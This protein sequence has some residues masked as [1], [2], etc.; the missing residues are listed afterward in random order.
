MNVLQ[1]LRLS[2]TMLFAVIVLPGTANAQSHLVDSLRAAANAVAPTGTLADTMLL[3]RLTRV[4]AQALNEGHL[5][6]SLAYNDRVLSFLDGMQERWGSNTFLKKLSL[7]TYRLRAMA[8]ED[9]GDLAASLKAAL[10]YE[11]LA[12]EMDNN[13]AIGGSL[14]QQAFCYHALSDDPNAQRC[15]HAA[16]TLLEQEPPG[17]D[18]EDVLNVLGGNFSG[19]GHSD[20]VFYYFRRLAAV[21]EGLGDANMYG[22]ACLNLTE[23]FVGQG[24]VDSAVKYMEKAKEVESVWSSSS[25]LAGLHGIQ[26]KVELMQGHY[27]RALVLADSALSETQ[28]KLD[29][30]AQIRNVRALA[31]AALGRPVEGYVEQ[32]R[33]RDAFLEDQGQERVRALAMV[34]SDHEREKEQINAKQL[35]MAEQQRKR[36]ITWGAIGLG[37][38]AVSLLFLFYTSRKGARKLA[39]KNAEILKAQEQLVQSEKQREAEQ[40]RTRIARDIHDEIGSELTKITLLGSEVKRLAKD[41]PARVDEA[42]ERMRGS[43]RQVSAALRDVVWAVDPGNDHVSS[44]VQHAEDHVQ[45]MVGSAGLQAEME[46]TQVGGDAL[47]NPQVKHS[48][49]MVLKEALNNT[50]KY[51]RADR[52]EVSLRT[53]G[54]RFDLR[55]KDNGSGFDASAEG[56]KGNGLRNMAAR[57]EQ[58][59]AQLLIRSVPGAGSE[60]TMTGSLTYA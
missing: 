40:V 52:L 35:L 38:L 7:K 58:I 30:L 32:Q 12:R 47:L 54:D 14:V 26:A 3:K 51:A 28:E 34:Q 8:L 23:E 59:G 55:V 11:D 9:K 36:Q 45:R 42:V 22:T 46:F 27:A 31:L 19:A 16:L 29:D 24:Q 44:L 41:D 6:T 10:Q 21:A 5:D 53:E 1:T 39:A 50:L 37:A 17:R 20:S 33:A 4:V 56:K 49:F 18:L 43:T 48:I 15:A 57:A 25:M 2:L 13:A 60:I